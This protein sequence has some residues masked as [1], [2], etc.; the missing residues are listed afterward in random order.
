[1]SSRQHPQA[2]GGKGEPVWARPEP[3]SRRP[4]Y[5]REQ[6]AAAALAIADAEG[7]EAVSMRRL[8]TELGA[9]TMTLYH[10]VETK[11][12]LLTL[13]NDAV[14]GE[15]LVPEAELAA[16]WREALIQLAG[17]SRAAMLRHPWALALPH[18]LIG[19][20]S[21]RHIEQ[22][23][24]AVADLP[25]GMAEKIELISLVDDYAL[26]FVMRDDLQDDLREGWIPS[27]ADYIRTQ[28][29]TGEFPHI[30]ALLGGDDPETALR[31]LI[32]D[33]TADDRFH[34]GLTRLLDGV[35]LHLE[36]SR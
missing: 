13:M 5:S 8:A 1:M 29:H 35:A 9:G 3:G 2:R 12:D 18:D 32:A 26:G 19:P 33:A 16:G 10:Y 17:R 34:R 21:L 22:S 6:I 20:N 31:R 36:R 30:E 27:V 28:L 14:M 4:R 25:V 7:I 15:L 23:L 24:A 11:H